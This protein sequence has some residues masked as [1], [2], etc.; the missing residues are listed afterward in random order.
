[1]PKPD[2]AFTPEMMHLL[3][4]EH[5]PI[6]GFDA[7]G[8][9]IT[10]ITASTV[11]C[12]L[13]GAV[14]QDL[15]D[16]VGGAA[17]RRLALTRGWAV[18]TPSLVRMTRRGYTAAQLAILRDV[19]L[20]RLDVAAS[21]GAMFGEDAGGLIDALRAASADNVGALA[22]ALRAV[23]VAM[24]QAGVDRTVDLC[25]TCAADIWRQA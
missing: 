2:A 19:R 10:K 7:G 9:P 20:M 22:E 17:A 5:A 8:K 6:V 14:D 1:M 13:C 3:R 25:A 11:R 24:G 23:E 12:D 15:S 4:R 21:K 18:F 16:P